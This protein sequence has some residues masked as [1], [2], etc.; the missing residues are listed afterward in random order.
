MRSYSRVG[1][2]APARLVRSGVAERLSLRL[3]Y[4]TL[5]FRLFVP[6]LSARLTVAPAVWPDCASNAFV[7]TLYSAMASEGG[8]KPT[9]PLLLP[10]LVLLGETRFGAPSRVNSLPPCAPLV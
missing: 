10:G 4:A 7:C 8:E 3:K 2:S 6:L 9:T 1:L 5:P